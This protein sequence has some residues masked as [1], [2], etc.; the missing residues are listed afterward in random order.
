MVG[1]AVGIVLIAAAFAVGMLT[2]DESDKVSEL[3]D[4]VARV[5]SELDDE[6]RELG[7]AEEEKKQADEKSESVEEEL[8]AERNFKGSGPKQVAE[9]E[10]ETDYPWEAAGEVGYLTL[11]P[12]GWVQEGEKWILTIEA[13]NTGHEPEDPFCGEAGATIIDAE[14]NNYTGEAVISGGTA[15]CGA[16]LQPG[17]TA[18]YK[19]EFKIP[20]NAVPVVAA[21]YG[22]Y[23]LEEEAKQWE[24]PH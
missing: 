22:E 13:K 5:E 8:A 2:A 17:S 11:K 15:N 20:S 19:G 4:K 1:V 10:Y 24:L 14:E 6:Q 12:V 23:E 9:Q 18:T 7:Y 21:I 16:S 3:E